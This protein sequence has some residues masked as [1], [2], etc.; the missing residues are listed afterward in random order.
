MRGEVKK[1]RRKEMT[2]I[3]KQWTLQLLF[4]EDYVTERRGKCERNSLPAAIL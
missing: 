4:G 1:K 2:M 3:M